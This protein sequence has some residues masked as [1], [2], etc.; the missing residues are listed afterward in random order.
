[1]DILLAASNF[2]NFWVIKLFISLN[3]KNK[4]DKKEKNNKKYYIKKTIDGWP[5]E[6]H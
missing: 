6:E 5:S 1:M 4:V 3:F 2:Y